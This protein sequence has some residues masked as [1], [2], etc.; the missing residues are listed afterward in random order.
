[1]F[2]KKLMLGDILFTNVDFQLLNEWGGVLH[3][4]ANDQK[5]Y[6]KNER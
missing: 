3:A 1:M 5:R 6:Y 4:V 2:L